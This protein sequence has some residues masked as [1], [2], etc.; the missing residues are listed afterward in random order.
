MTLA[1]RLRY[2]ALLL[3]AL[4]GTAVSGSLW[5]TEPDLP[6]RTRS[7]SRCFRDQRLL[8]RVRGLGADAAPGAARA[9]SVIAAWMAVVFSGVFV[10]FAVGGGAAA[11]ATADLAA[12][13][14]WSWWRS[15]W[16]AGSGRATVGPA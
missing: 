14:G 13:S 4:A 10:V 5:L 7:R 11:V 15:R 8:G 6:A 16:R 1:P 3:V 2:T 9:Q 12:S